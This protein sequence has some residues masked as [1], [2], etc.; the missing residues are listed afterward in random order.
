MIQGAI[1]DADGT[2]LDSMGM[3]DTVGE[4]YLISQGVQPPAG[5][6][7]TLFPLSL[8]QCAVYLK[9][10]FA[11]PLAPSAIEAGINGVI[12]SFYA[13]EVVAKAG[14]LDFLRGLKAKGVPLY[15]ATAT[16]REVITKGLERT[17]ILPLLDG[18]VTC[19]DLGVDKRTP[20][21]FDYARDRMGTATESTWVFEDAVHAAA[22]AATPKGAYS[23]NSSAPA[24]TAPSRKPTPASA[25]PKNARRDTFTVSRRGK[26]SS[27]SPARSFVAILSPS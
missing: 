17:G 11:L 2:L 8:A 15:L 18:L 22:T 12:R 21:I 27:F 14:V 19:G 23:P 25:R 3:W 26:R 9:D 4:R 1:F 16:D 20:E 7:E 10:R 13:G 5:L 6:R 24:N